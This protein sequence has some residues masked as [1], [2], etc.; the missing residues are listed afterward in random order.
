MTDDSERIGNNIDAGSPIYKKH[1]FSLSPGLVRQAMDQI[2]PNGRFAPSAEKTAQP[3][4]KAYDEKLSSISSSP[5]TSAQAF[6]F[7]AKKY[8]DRFA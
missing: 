1:M 2:T 4:R 6:M 7:Y 3:L 5:A 8:F